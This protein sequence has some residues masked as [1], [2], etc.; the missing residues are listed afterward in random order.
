MLS[1]P[2]VI[3]LVV[4]QLGENIGAVARAMMNCGVTE[5]RLVAPRDGWPNPSAYPSASGA[6]KIL[7][8][9]T[10][11]PSLSEAIADL[12]FVAATTARPRDMAKPVF[13]AEGIASEICARTNLQ[14]HGKCGLVFG[15]ERW[16]L[17]NEDIMLC[18]AVVTIP[19]N[20]EFTS[21][22]LAQGVLLCAYGWW[23]CANTLAKGQPEEYALKIGTSEPAKREEVLHLLETLVQY[24]ENSGYYPTNDMKPVMVRNLY[25]LV[26]RA[27]LTTQEVRSL[28]GVMKSLYVHI[29]KS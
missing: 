19:L 1:S 29:Q 28:F 23:M 5:L 14:N 26:M 20:P 7:D 15:G 11:F 18:D 6:D 24:L 13:N 8:E 12:H 16:G 25:N 27:G 21:L 22:N 10:V 3:I 17:P 2:P 9:V 4:P